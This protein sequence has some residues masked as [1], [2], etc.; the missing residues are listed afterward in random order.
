MTAQPDSL[1][2]PDGFDPTDPELNEAGVPHAELL[3][4]RKHAP[5]FWI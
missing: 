5:V 1:D 3:A 2:L 4:L